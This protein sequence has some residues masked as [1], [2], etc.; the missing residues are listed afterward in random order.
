MHERV[1]L[2]DATSGVQSEARYYAP[3]VDDD[4]WDAGRYTPAAFDVNRLR[5]LL[6]LALALG[7]LAVPPAAA[8]LVLRRCL[9]RRVTVCNI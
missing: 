6:A 7:Q 9:R 5:V 8:C 2:T 4:E 3:W 1:V